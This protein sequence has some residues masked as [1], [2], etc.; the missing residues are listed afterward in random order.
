MDDFE[1][2]SDNGTFDSNA[3]FYS[4]DLSSSAVNTNAEAIL[5]TK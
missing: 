2:A 1:D 4:N 5:V 3:E